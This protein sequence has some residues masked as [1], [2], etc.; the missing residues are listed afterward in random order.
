MTTAIVPRNADASHLDFS[1]EQVDLIKRTICKGATDDELALFIEVA[2]SRRLDPFARQ[3]CAVR[4]WDS[5]E[6][7]MVMSHQTTIDGLRLI[8]ERTGLYRGQTIVQWCG[9]AGLWVDVWLDQDPPR[10]ARVGVYKQ[11]FVESVSSVAH[12][13]EYVQRGKN[14]VTPMWQKMP[15]LMLGKVAEALALRRAFPED[16]SG[17]YTG[18]EMSAADS[19]APIT[20][21]SSVKDIVAEDDPAMQKRMDAD[22]EHRRDSEVMYEA[23]KSDLTKIVKGEDPAAAVELLEV[24]CQMNGTTWQA[25]HRNTKRKVETLMKRASKALELEVPTVLEWLYKSE[26]QPTLTMPDFR[27]E[28]VE[29]EI[30]EVQ[31]VILDGAPLG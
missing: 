23:W 30:V 9:P 11:G 29:A 19:P 1:T 27:T 10:A 2:R 28:P 26:A 8:A 4:R 6:K 3:I 14:G 17:L 12:W 13:D 7:R 5:R 31:T 21:V 20:A 25:M 18:D 22:A 16:M 24:W 15:A